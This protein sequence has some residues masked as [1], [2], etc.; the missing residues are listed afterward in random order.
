MFV[1]LHWTWPN[2]VVDIRWIN[3]VC[4][5]KALLIL[6]NLLPSQTSTSQQPQNEAFR[7]QCLRLT[8]KMFSTC[9]YPTSLML[10][11]TYF[12]YTVYSNFIF[13]NNIWFWESE[14]ISIHWTNLQPWIFSIFWEIQF[15][16]NNKKSFIYRILYKHHLTFTL[17]SGLPTY[18]F[19]SLHL[20]LSLLL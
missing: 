19:L 5:N 18:S 7:Q 10:P 17:T 1:G 8:I 20:W 11:P 15:N 2:S 6:W 12:L 3:L 13:S 16:A 9:L 14:F 4:I